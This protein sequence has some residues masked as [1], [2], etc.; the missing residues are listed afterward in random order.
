MPK[1]TF[2]PGQPI[3]VCKTCKQLVWPT[4]IGKPARHMT[5]A[6]LDQHHQAVAAAPKE[7]K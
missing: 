4:E 6:I 3:P 5:M 2:V 1:Y 7:K